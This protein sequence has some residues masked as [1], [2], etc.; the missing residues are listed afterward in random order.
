MN[1]IAEF[2]ATAGFMPHGY[3][4][5]WSPG[6]LWTYVGADAV[7]ALSY[8]SIPIALWTF[9]KRRT[10]LPFSWLFFMFAL[11]ILACGTTHL[12]A[13]LDIWQ[14][15][16]WLDAS[17][18]T[19]TAAASLATAIVIWP[20]IPKA[21]ALPSPA[22]LKAAND[23]LLA[24]IA[25]RRETEAQLQTLNRELEQ[26]VAQRTA[27]LE[28]A[29]QSLR[30]SET[31]FR[32]TFEQAAV[33]I[34]HVDT[35]GRWMRVNQK[36]CDIVGYT[37]EELLTQTFQDI[38][39]PDDLDTDLAQMRQILDGHLDTYTLE[40]RY[41]SKDGRELWIALTVALVH[42]EA[43]LPDYFISVVADI[44]ER[45]R[46]EEALRVSREQLRHLS[47]H[48]LQI[49]E[50]ENRRIARELHDD[51]AQTLSALKMTIAMMENGLPDEEAAPSATRNPNAAS[52]LVD[53][54]ID[55]VR[56]IAAELR[57]AMLDDLGLI[58]AIDWLTN[59]FSR[60]HNVRVVRHIDAQAVTFNRAGRIEL[61]RI[62]QEALANVARHSGATEV[63]LDLAC[64]DAHCIVRIAD[65]GRGAEFDVHR[66]ARAFGLLGIH[67]RAS[68]L[69]GDIQIST[70]PGAGFVL[71]ATLPL[72]FIEAEEVE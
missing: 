3:C 42:D 72:S 18:K 44:A 26:R 23:K 4:F 31:R 34:A 39:H 45:K 17:I 65:N 47:A 8:Y 12:T 28:H 25:A 61:F 7:I 35:S 1:A 51:F 22:Q 40:K 46:A 32:T 64:D 29:L 11:F 13:I 21:L 63:A 36:L 41:L 27:E 37:R 70:S 56:Q 55:S 50:E 57:P 16:Y 2:F 58:A 54:L 6:L 19:I 62:I 20:L 66:S 43:G 14:P 71:T 33:G 53:K 60:R 10:E 67:E 30:D 38:T 59:E 15:A 52:T 48:I 69:G 5:L 9:A 68:L 49:R 24:E